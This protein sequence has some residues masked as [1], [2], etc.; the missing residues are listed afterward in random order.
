MLFCGF[1]LTS[2]F[3]MCQLKKYHQKKDIILKS[4]FWVERGFLLFKAPP[5]LSFKEKLVDPLKQEK[6]N[7]LKSHAWDPFILLTEYAYSFKP[8]K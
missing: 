4:W 3:K 5:S 2:Y 1:V 8:A 6:K 7:L